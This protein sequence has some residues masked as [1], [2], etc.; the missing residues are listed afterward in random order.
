LSLANPAS[1]NNL[2]AVPKAR[3]FPEHTVGQI[4]VDHPLVTNGVQALLDKNEREATSTP[5]ELW[6]IARMR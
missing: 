3:M 1:A 6:K 5:P 2:H 4:S